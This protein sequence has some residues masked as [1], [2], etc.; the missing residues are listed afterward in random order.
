MLEGNK[1]EDDKILTNQVQIKNITRMDMVC[2]ER[3]KEALRDLNDEVMLVEGGEKRKRK[4][5][6][7]RVCV[8]VILSVEISG[9]WSGP[10]KPC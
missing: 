10:L 5:S 7:R 2:E 6:K 9:W 1:D 4:K 3:K 8:C